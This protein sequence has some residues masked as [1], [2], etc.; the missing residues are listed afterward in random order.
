MEPFGQTGLAY[1]HGRVLSAFLFMHLPADDLAA[2]NVEDQVQAVEQAFG[3][4]GQEG[5]VPTPHLVWTSGL[6]ALGFAD[7]PGGLHL[8]TMVQYSG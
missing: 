1:Q 3:R 2:I 4:G 6:I 8:A 7:M 5:N